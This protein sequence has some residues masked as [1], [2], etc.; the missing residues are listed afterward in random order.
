ML[1]DP[2][3]LYP[4]DYAVRALVL[5]F[6][7]KFVTP[8]HLTVLRLV[9]TPIVVYLL[10]VGNF[11]FGIPL[12]VIAAATDAVDGSL[13]RVRRNITSWGTLFD[14]VADKLLIGLVAL[15]FAMRFIHPVVVIV[16]VVFDFLPLLIWAGRIK[17]RRSILTAN[18]W[19]KIKMFLQ[20]LS[21]TLLLIG[22]ALDQTACV[23]IAEW[24]LVLAT[25]FAAIATIT[26]SL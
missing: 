6:V 7:P 22:V 20:F 14:P 25:A 18:T 17:E 5:P 9:L 23:D 15:V 11:R 2:Y 1:R 12:F 19:G 8:N 10:A 26:Y 24:I 4:H 13:A 16:A 3:T 21:V